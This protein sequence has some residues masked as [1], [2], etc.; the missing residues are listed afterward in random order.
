MTSES[1]S[2]G[3]QDTQMN[4]YVLKIQNHRESKW[5]KEGHR[6]ETVSGLFDGADGAER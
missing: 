3:S 4:W 6:A 2:E 1:V 5:E